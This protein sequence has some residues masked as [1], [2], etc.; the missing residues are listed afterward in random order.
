MHRI[1]AGGPEAEIGTQRRSLCTGIGNTGALARGSD[2]A[3]NVGWLQCRD[4]DRLIAEA[5]PQETPGDPN[6]NTA[7][8]LAEPSRTSHVLIEAAQL[9]LDGV[10]LRHGR[11]NN[12]LIAENPQQQ[13]AAGTEIAT[14]SKCR[15][16]TVAARQVAIKEPLNR[17]LVE[18]LDCKPG[19]THPPRK[20]RDGVDVIRSGAARVAAPPHQALDERPNMRCKLAGGDP[21]SE[22]G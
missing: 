22:A 9:F 1:T 2:K 15:R 3:P 18:A 10:W 12:T 5:R 11:W 19:P 8:A 13:V 4:D 20:M 17:H 7:R 6:A 16:R 21:V 14:V